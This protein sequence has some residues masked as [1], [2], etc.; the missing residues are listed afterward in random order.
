MLGQADTLG[1]RV[2]GCVINGYLTVSGLL[3]KFSI[4]K[5]EIVSKSTLLGE[6]EGVVAKVKERPRRVRGEEGKERKEREEKEVSKIIKERS[7]NAGI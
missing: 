7:Y 4:H 1:A 6:R 3:R 5:R 2:D